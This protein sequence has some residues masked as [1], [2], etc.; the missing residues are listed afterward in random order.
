MSLGYPWGTYVPVGTYDRPD[1]EQAA[2]DAELAD[3][4]GLPTDEYYAVI[5]ERMGVVIQDDDAE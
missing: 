1:V 5:A 4:A 3:I 2:L